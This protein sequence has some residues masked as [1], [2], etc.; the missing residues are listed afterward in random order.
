MGACSA[1]SREENITARRH[2]DTRAE[3]GCGVAQAVVDQGHGRHEQI[4]TIPLQV[5]DFRY[6]DAAVVY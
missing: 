5:G 3:S 2:Q 4:H 1:S 6:F